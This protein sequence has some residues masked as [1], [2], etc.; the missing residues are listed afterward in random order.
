M[1]KILKLCSFVCEHNGQ[2][3]KIGQCSSFI[4]LVSLNRYWYKE[5]NDG[6]DSETLERK[7]Q[8]ARR[9]LTGHG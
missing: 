3:S 7:Q 4:F 8:K 9:T 5:G 6:R 1:V 2:F